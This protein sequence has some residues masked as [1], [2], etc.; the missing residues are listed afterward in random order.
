MPE[1]LTGRRF[2][3]FVGI[4]PGLGQTAIAY[5][6]RGESRRFFFGRMTELTEHP[7]WEAFERTVLDCPTVWIVVEFPS[8]YLQNGAVVRSTALELVRI[9]RKRFP[10][11]CKFYTCNPQSLHAALTK[12][13]KG[14][15]KDRA[16][17]RARLDCVVDDGL[18][19]DVYD[20]LNLLTIAS[21]DALRSSVG[22]PRK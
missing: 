3:L 17:L 6:R 5:R 19:S 4:D 8:R 15:A 12:G 18:P 10:R 14:E 9:L 22:K 20:A 21:N 16:K 1:G 7:E 11:R 2:D 13:L